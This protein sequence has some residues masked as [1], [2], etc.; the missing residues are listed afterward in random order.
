MPTLGTERDRF[1][2]LFD[3]TSIDPRSRTRKVEMQVLVIGMMRTG[4]KCMSA[5]SFGVSRRITDPS[6]S[7]H[8][9]CPRTARIP[10]CISH[11]LND[12]EPQGL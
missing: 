10:R 7:S 11:D 5:T 1:P 8:Q 4:T 9:S 2:E 12:E 6:R 3:Q